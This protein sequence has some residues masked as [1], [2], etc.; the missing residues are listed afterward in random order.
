MFNMSVQSETRG[1]K[2]KNIDPEMFIRLVAYYKNKKESL[3]PPHESSLFAFFKA[4][5]SSAEHF[6]TIKSRREQLFT[7]TPE[8]TESDV[9]K[10][11]EDE[12]NYIY[13]FENK[14]FNND[15]FDQ[16]RDGESKRYNAS[17]GKYDFYNFFDNRDIEKANTIFH[18]VPADAKKKLMQRLR[19]AKFQQAHRYSN[20]KVGIDLDDRAFNQIKRFTEQYGFKTHS[21]AVMVM[22]EMASSN[23]E[24]DAFNE[25]LTSTSKSIKLSPHELFKKNSNI[26]LVLSW[27]NNNQVYHSG[28]TYKFYMNVS[29]PTEH[30]AIEVCE[31]DY[32][33]AL[34]QLRQSNRIDV[35]GKKQK[36]DVVGTVSDG[37]MVL[38]NNN[39]EIKI[40]TLSL[41]ALNEL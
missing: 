35:S 29:L 7:N 38:F 41:V 21:Y 28:D 12:F 6:E 13:P 3:V 15:S 37:K 27:V 11:L 39:D 30:H 26:D 22:A 19:K 9:F 14:V 31:I 10:L 8:I 17:G 5:S 4:F 1:R 16:V 34:Y 32:N 25:A 40:Y 36:A 18:K 20:R 2:P 23:Y 24:S 33:Q